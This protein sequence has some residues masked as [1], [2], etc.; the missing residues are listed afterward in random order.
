MWVFSLKSSL[1]MVAVIVIELKDWGESMLK[2]Q[3]GRKKL[4]SAQEPLEETVKGGNPSNP[5][6][7]LIFVPYS[8]KE[9]TVESCK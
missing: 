3:K 1:W 4:L 7:L 9:V 5:H 8:V 6:L 2:T